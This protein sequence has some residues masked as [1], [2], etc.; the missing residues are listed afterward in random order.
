MVHAPA[1]ITVGT[2]N[3]GG[4]HSPRRPL[5]PLPQRAAQLCRRL[6]DAGIDVLNLQEVF[7]HGYFRVL[8]SHLRS[9]PYLGY[10]WRPWG[11]AGGLVTF[12]RL[13]LGRPAYRSFVGATPTAG[14][15]PF[16]LRHTVDTALH[17]LLVVDLAELPV[18]V[19]ST[20]LTANRDGDWTEGNRHFELQRRQLAR[21]NRVL[22]RPRRTELTVVTGDFNIASDS[23]HYPAILGEGTRRDPFSGTNPTTFH[24]VFLPQRE[25]AHR[26]DYVLLTGDEQRFKVLDAATLFP[27]PV[28]VDGEQLYLSDHIGLTVHIGISGQG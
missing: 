9:F 3:I 25:S 15:P 2:L 17:G 5:V 18:T 7:D 21:L 6:D 13:R 11:P 22:A 19:A 20:H 26:I 24:S 12:S 16:R 4:L 14:R 1:S 27:E 10:R 23:V 8:R 28:T